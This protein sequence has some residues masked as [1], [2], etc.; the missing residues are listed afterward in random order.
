MERPGQEKYAVLRENRPAVTLST[1]IP[2]EMAWDQ[3]RVWR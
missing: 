2:H 3:N 1:K